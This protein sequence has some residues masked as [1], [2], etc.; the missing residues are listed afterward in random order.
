MIPNSD[1]TSAAPDLLESDLFPCFATGIPVP[2]PTNAAALDILSVLAPSPPVPTV[3]MAL[4]GAFIF[5]A[6][7]LSIVAPDAIISD[8]SPL[9][10]KPIRKAPIWAFVAVPFNNVVNAKS[11]SYQC[12]VSC[13]DSFEIIFLKLRGLF[14]SLSSQF[15]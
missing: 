13:L 6:L 3:S 2:E 14:I 4:A 1:K 15:I 8:V 9:I 10:L 12:R 7:F 11:N 5:I